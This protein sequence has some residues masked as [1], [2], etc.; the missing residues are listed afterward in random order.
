MATTKKIV[1]KNFNGVDYDDLYP[2]TVADQVVTNVNKE[3]I[4]ATEKAKLA[5]VAE[6]ANNYQHPDTHPVTMI[7]GLA[8][9]ATSGSYNDL[10]NKPTLGTAAS[11]NTGTTSGTVPLIGANG[12]LDVSL[13]PATAITDTF[14]VA[15]Q[16]AMLALTAQV[17]DVAIRTDVN[18]SFILRVEPA[19]SLANWE[20]LL[21]PLAAVS[22]VAG[23]TG[24]V[25]LVAS[26][27]GLGNVAN[28]TK[29]TMFT[30]PAFTG[31]PTAPTAA[32]TTNNT[33]IATTAYVKNQAYATLASPTFTGTP[34]APTAAVGNDSTQIATTAFV[35][36]AVVAVS[37][38]MPKIVVSATQPATPAAG[39]FWYEELA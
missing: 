15:S 1:M 5:T 6:D 3:F 34:K 29:A 31:T 18:K 39:D 8:T 13:M 32:T 20:E 27:V 19:T 37:S 16:A 9:V 35:Q 25:T 38:S 4:T 10:S 22:S 14:P 17:G 24:A 26:D 36:A 11:K 30:S 21:A 23:K 28:E 7:T 33:Q 2:K 12:K